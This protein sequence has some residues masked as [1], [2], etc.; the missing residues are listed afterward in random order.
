MKSFDAI[1]T[2]P[3]TA[4]TVTALSIS[5]LATPSFAA[6][7]SKQ[8][9][10][11]GRATSISANTIRNGKGAPSNTLGV[12]GDF[13]IDTLKLN[14]YGPKLNGTWPAPVS[15]RGPAGVDGK[16]GSNGSDGKNGANGISG[17]GSGSVGAQGPRGLQGV[18]GVAGPQGIQGVAGTAGATGPIGLT[19]LTGGVG[20]A[21]PTGATGPAGPSG[22]SGAAGPA[23]PAGP[24]G[25]TGSIG[26]TGPAGAVG[27]QGIQGLTGLTGNTGPT[28][29]TGPSQVLFG[30]IGFAQQIK[31]GP[32]ASVNSNAFGTFAAGKDY[33]VHLMIYGVRAVSAFVSL[34]I[35]V[36][37][38]GGSPTIQTSYLISNGGSYR[39]A[40]G[41]NDTNLDVWI[42][43][44]GSA[45]GTS[46]QLGA[47]VSA[48]ED[49]ST[50]FVT[51]SGAYLSQLVG[52]LT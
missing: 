52:S 45:V 28:G 30:T 21:G 34:K 4:V 2:I 35:N 16:A 42:T 18:Q 26:L 24:S 43:V 39:T 38:V 25:A 40:F 33:L 17:S 32:G 29:A 31:A 51:L 13:Y 12:D 15:L 11:A 10:K 50:D 46:Y 1:K 6:T 20:P 44:D 22:S 19:G 41:E 48:L 47:N 8:L 23:G 14:F 9:H 36:Y 5:F 49:T 27:P 7:A 37:G 3:I